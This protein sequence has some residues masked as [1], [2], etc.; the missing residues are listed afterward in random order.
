[1]GIRVCYKPFQTL[2][3]MLSH[4]KDPV[5][6][7]HGQDVV[8]KIPCTYIGQTGRKL[9]QRLDERAVRQADFNSSALAEHA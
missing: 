4:P 3:Q 5:P 2:S 6:D 8:Y 1:L 7:L 9:S